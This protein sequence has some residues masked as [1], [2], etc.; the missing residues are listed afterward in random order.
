M[1]DPRCPAC[2]SELTFSHAMRMPNP[3]RYRC[4]ECCAALEAGP[5]HKVA[6]FV[7][8]SLMTAVVGVAL[9]LS[10]REVLVA[11]AALT[12]MTAGA[13]SLVAGAVWT[14]QRTTFTRKAAAEPQRAL[15]R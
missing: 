9:D 6:L 3:W 15:K 13:L 7:L 14:W 1:N 10:A 11:P 5:R 4:P 12:L 8:P 2:R